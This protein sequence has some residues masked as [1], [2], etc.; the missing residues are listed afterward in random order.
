MLG[1]VV[2]GYVVL[3]CVVLG[4][5]VLYCIVLCCVVLRCVVLC[6][7]VLCFVVLCEVVLQGCIVLYCMLLQVVRWESLTVTIW[8]WAT[9][10]G[11]VLNSVN[12]RTT[13]RKASCVLR[14]GTL[15]WKV[16]THTRLFFMVLLKMD[17]PPETLVIFQ[18]LWHLTNQ[19]ILIVSGYSFLLLETLCVK[20]SH[21]HNQT[22]HSLA[23]C[24][25][26]LISKVCIHLWHVYSALHSR[27]VLTCDLCI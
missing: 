13:N 23:T 18:L 6:C 8:H 2:L 14:D 12:S 26:S 27:F 16:N 5:V 24:V 20:Y 22:L 15:E 11:L 17:V 1:Y 3:Y 4:Y 7:V 21:H 25:F 9:W 19:H 10:H